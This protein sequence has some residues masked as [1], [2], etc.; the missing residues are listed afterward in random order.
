MG[1]DGWADDAHGD[2]GGIQTLALF[3]TLGN[4]GGRTVSVSVC[5]KVSDNHFM[6]LLLWFSYLHKSQTSLESYKCPEVV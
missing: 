2:T 1:D 4:Q 6:Y 5:V 3:N